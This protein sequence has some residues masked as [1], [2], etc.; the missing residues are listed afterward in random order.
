MRTATLSQCL[1]RQCMYGKFQFDMPILALHSHIT[2]S[3]S[4]T[5]YLFIAAMLKTPTAISCGGSYMEVSLE[6]DSSVYMAQHVFVVGGH[7]FTKDES[8]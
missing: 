4:D 3:H 7:P 8:L 5:A 1:T 2:R 6:D